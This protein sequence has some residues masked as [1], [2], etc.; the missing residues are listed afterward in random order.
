MRNYLFLIPLIAFVLFSCSKDENTSPNDMNDEDKIPQ[1][2]KVDIPSSLSEDTRGKNDKSACGDTICGAELYKNLR[3]FVHVGESAADVIERIMNGIRK[4]NINRAMSI[5]FTSDEDS[6]EKDLVVEENIT[7]E[8][9]DYEFCL[10]ISD[11]DNK[12]IQVFWNTNPISG[13]AILDPYHINQTTTDYDILYKVAYAEATTN[14][15]HQMEVD[16]YNL[17]VTPLDSGSINN[18]KMF[19]GKNG[20]LLDVY[21]NTNHPLIGG[22]FKYNTAYEQGANYAFVAKVDESQDIAVVELGLPPSIL[23]SSDEVLS[24]YGIR[25]VLM[26]HLTGAFPSVDTNFLAPYI[27]DARPPGYFDDTGF[28]SGGV[29]PNNGKD[30]SALVDL[31]G[32]APFVPADIDNLTIEFK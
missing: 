16:I 30:Y 26:E 3:F 2:F 4:H 1:N 20:D 15:E 22:I 21:G 28:L 29:D 12:A 11:N 14:Y 6:R 5:S 9:T 8:G 31:S 24:T 13:V 32:L 25:N 7:F 10:T 23:T 18:L 17:P 19:V 27:E